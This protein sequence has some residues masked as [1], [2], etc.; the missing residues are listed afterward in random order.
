MKTALKLLL[1]ITLFCLGHTTL[2]AQMNDGLRFG[3]T[4]G[5]NG[6]KLYDDARADDKK[7]RIAYTFGGFSQI[8]LGKGRFSLR[9]ELLF[10]AK[11]ASFDFD[12]TTRSEVKL[13]YVELP[14]SLQWHLLVL[15]NVHAG[16]YASLLVDSKGKLKD[17][18]G[19][20]IASDFDKNNFNTIDYGWHIGGG[21]DLG[22]MGL[23]LRVSRGLRGIAKE[24]SIQDYLGDLKNGNWALT[25]NW[26]F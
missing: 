12:E 22:N 26:A 21:I 10:T 17:A 13:S 7:S 18:N 4:A 9:P 2:V 16:M 25:Y 5:L 19:N 20:V 14:V 6:S 8:P 11:G 24:G 3:L 15:L 1:I 23:H